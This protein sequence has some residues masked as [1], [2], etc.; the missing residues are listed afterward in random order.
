MKQ[1]LIGGIVGY[2]LTSI[3][4]IPS[5]PTAFWWF[6][7]LLSALLAYLYFVWWRFDN[8]TYGDIDDEL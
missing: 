1:Y 7:T 2:L 5:P 3:F 6:T 8:A 4:S